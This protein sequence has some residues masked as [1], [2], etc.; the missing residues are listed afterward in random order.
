MLRAKWPGVFLNSARGKT[1]VI[2]NWAR[3]CASIGGN[4]VFVADP[5]NPGCRLPP[6]RA[7]AVSTYAQRGKAAA[8]AA[9]WRKGR[10]GTVVGSYLDMLARRRRR[11][12][13][14]RV[15]VVDLD[16]EWEGLNPEWPLLKFCL[17]Y[18]SPSPRDQRGS[19]MP[20]SA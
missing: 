17:L 12:D 6:D 18:T 16:D 10:G 11:A 13:A 9:A 5:Q 19:R 15:L 8:A 4:S 2:M 1:E 20:S 7:L 14:T 3:R